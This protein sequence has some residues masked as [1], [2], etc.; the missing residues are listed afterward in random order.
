MIRESTVARNGEGNQMTIE[1]TAGTPAAGA[2]A[3]EFPPLTSGQVG[4][5]AVVALL[6]WTFA[7]YDL[8]TF[9]N[10]L[11][12]IQADFGWSNATASYVAT[13]VGLGSLVI[14][15][16]VGPLIDFVGRRFALVVTTGG[17]AISS[18][19][20]ALAIGPV[21]LVLVRS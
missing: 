8:I 16:T 17:A 10:L 14:A 4:Y 11:P 21:S 3:D 20:A 13:F 2:A 6:A 1:M 9:G 19:L 12:L 15:L 18:G 5:T 7:V